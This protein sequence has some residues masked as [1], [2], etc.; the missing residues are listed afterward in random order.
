MLAAGAEFQSRRAIPLVEEIR[1]AGV[2]VFVY[3]LLMVADRV[4]R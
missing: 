3:M 1:N 2:G 4:A